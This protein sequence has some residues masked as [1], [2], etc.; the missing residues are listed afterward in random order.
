MRGYG[1]PRGASRAQIGP[2]PIQSPGVRGGGPVLKFVDRAMIRVTG[3][4]GGAGASSFRRESFVPQGG[5]DG[6]DGGRGGSIYLRADSNL[7]TL[8]DYSYRPRRTAQRGAH[9]K[10]GNKTGKSGEDEYRPVPPGTVV[11]DADTGAPIGELIASA[12]S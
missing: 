7:Q 8:L 10:G 2:M 6:G 12:A 5:P 1:T 4:A 9:G 3:G 11:N